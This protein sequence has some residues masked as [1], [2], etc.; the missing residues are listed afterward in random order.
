MPTLP[1]VVVDARTFDDAGVYKLSDELALIFT[2]DFFTP[3]VDDPSDYG[4]IAAAN[5]LSDAYAMG[6]KPLIALNLLG[7]PKGKVPPDVVAAIV[8]GAVEKCAEAGVA[9]LGGHSIRN[10]EPIFGL[11]VVGTVHPDRILRN[12]AAR[13]GLDVV[14][15]KPIG[16]GI[17][18]TCAMR[19]I[20]R[21]EEVAEAVKWMSR[22][23]SHASKCALDAGAECATDIT[24]YGL[25][26][27]LAEIARASGVTIEVD[28]ASVPLIEGTRRLL[29]ERA[30]PGGT[31]G[32]YQALMDGELRA[33]DA[34]GESKPGAGKPD[35]SFPEDM[36][37]TERLL[38]CDAQTSGGLAIC[39]EPDKTEALLAALREGGD[40][41]AAK[42][43]M[44]TDKSTFSIKITL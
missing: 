17:I 23:N 11:A 36:P 5:A 3:V 43:G 18:T 42:I 22:L 33:G 9:V 20:A 25:L 35:V 32:N 1:G 7:I 38:L 40:A 30:I 14:L 15:T 31:V 6:G 16:T 10:P 19:D 29:A 26:G 44:T 28:A 34:A 8:A 21:A 12:D 24:G 27:H 39:V 41:H 13:P 2:T 4:R 37:E